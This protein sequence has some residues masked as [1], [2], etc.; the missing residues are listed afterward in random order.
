M[1]FKI[2]VKKEDE[3]EFNY[4]RSFNIKT[5]R[6]GLYED[7]IYNVIINW[8]RLLILFGGNKGG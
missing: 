6:T 1:I 7:F 5:F 4:I 3:V 2:Y 8:I